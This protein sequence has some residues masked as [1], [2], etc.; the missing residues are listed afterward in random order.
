MTGPN[1]QRENNIDYVMNALFSGFD[2]EVD[3][4][5]MDN[6]LWLGHDKPSYSLPNSSILL[7]DRIWV[8]TKNLKAA[9]YCKKYGINFFWHQTDD[10]TITSKGFFWTYPGKD[11]SKNSIAVLPETVDNWDYSM[12]YGVCTDYPHRVEER[13]EEIIM[14]KKYA[15]YVYKCMCV[16]DCPMNFKNFIDNE[17]NRN[18]NNNS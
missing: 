1:D 14:E 15:D 2:I 17:K 8:H 11:L 5:V 16:E 12:C 3:L 9:D 13:L 18:R 10:F 6:G 7:D 4:W